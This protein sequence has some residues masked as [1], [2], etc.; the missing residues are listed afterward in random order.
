[1]FSRSGW[2]RGVI[3]IVASRIVERFH[4]PVFVLGEENGLAQGSGR[5]IRPFHLL[6]ALESMPELF[7]KF[8]GH[9]QAAGVTMDTAR[10][11]EFRL[12]LNTYATSRLTPDQ[13]RPVLE[14]DA[15]VELAELSERSV[16]EV[17][18][19]APFGFGNPTPSFLLRD[20]EVA[21]PPTVIKDRHMR[22]R[23]KQG[24]RFQSVIA[25]NFAERIAEFEPGSRLDLAVTLEEDDYS[26]SRGYENWSASLKDARPSSK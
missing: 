7:Q 18:M 15:E 20:V 23:V 3:G 12:R 13:L 14:L 2:H 19:L 5:S 9:R 1:V 24:R 17:F 21:A 10:V 11:D 4:R 25:W 16:H 26:A 6:E 22:I 8:G